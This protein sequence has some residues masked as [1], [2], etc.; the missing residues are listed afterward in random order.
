MNAA[1]TGIIGFVDPEF[2]DPVERDVLREM[3]Y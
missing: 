2:A 3:K 1:R